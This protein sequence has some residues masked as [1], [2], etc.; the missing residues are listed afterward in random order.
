M[1]TLIDVFNPVTQCCEMRVEIFKKKQEMTFQCGGI[2]NT[3]NLLFFCIS[4]YV[5]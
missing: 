1:R 4:I 2:P 3:A 5:S